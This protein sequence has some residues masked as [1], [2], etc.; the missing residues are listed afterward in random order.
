MKLQKVGIS[1]LSWTNQS[2]LELGDHITYEKSI[3]QAAHSGF[4]GVE[5]GRKFP[6][7]PD[8]VK[9]TLAKVG[10]EPVS[11]WYSGYLGERSVTEEWPHAL[12]ELMHLKALGCEVMVY[13]EC[14]CGPKEGASAVLSDTPPLRNLELASYAKRVSDFA[15]RVAEAGLV[16][17]YHPHVMMPV[18]TVDEID[19]FMT[20]AGD[21]VHLLLDTGHIA[22]SGGDYQIVMEKWW[23]KISHIHLKDIR[24]SVY[25]AIDPKQTKFDQAIIDGVFTVPGDGDLNFEPLIAKIARDGYKGWLLVEAEQDP[26]KASPQAMAKTAFDYISELLKRYDLPFERNTYSD[27]L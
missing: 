23:D 17:V 15:D 26:L 25:D 19:R 1:P 12:P 22:M 9:A 13:G 18:E 20:A 3:T 21:S 5:L 24:Q 8:V 4:T 14:A 11:A 7:D 27:G 16:L 2:I 6:Q 10:L